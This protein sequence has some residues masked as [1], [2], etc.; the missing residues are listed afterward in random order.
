MVLA[1]LIT[2]S[3]GLTDRERSRPE[4]T[5]PVACAVVRSRYEQRST[6]PTGPT[7]KLLSRSN[8]V[9]WGVAASSGAF[10]WLQTFLPKFK[11]TLH[12]TQQGKP[13]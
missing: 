13:L 3:D 12:H 9:P 6:G 5:P 4:S 11:T 2:Y 1:L 10:I 8:G 7:V